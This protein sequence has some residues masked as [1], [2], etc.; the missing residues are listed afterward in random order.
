ML[1]NFWH[2]VLLFFI[3]SE[4]AAGKDEGTPL[5][6]YVIA[7]VAVCGLLAVAIVSA[8][9][10]I[11]F[12]RR[13][14]NVGNFE[15]KNEDSVTAWSSQAICSE[16][17][18]LNTLIKQKNELHEWNTLLKEETS[19]LQFFLWHLINKKRRCVWLRFFISKVASHRRV[20]DQK[21]NDSYDQ[22][23]ETSSKFFFI[24]S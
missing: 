6:A 5:P 16:Q 8:T 23:R 12:R 19:S 22:T 18:Q 20:F 15:L 3:E 9:V 24:A 1:N 17:K 21:H 2:D 4:A 13:S 7:V 11:V 10:L 14:Q